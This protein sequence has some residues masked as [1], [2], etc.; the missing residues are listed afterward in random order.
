M[1]RLARHKPWVTSPDNGLEI[2]LRDRGRGAGNP[3]PVVAASAQRIV[4]DLRALRV[5]NVHELGGRALGGV[6][7]DGGGH[8]F[9]AGLHGLGVGVAAAGGLA[10][11]GWVDDGFRGGAWGCR[12]VAAGA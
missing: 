3:I 5:P 10:A 9:D 6:G 1:E 11:T 12:L 8:G 2:V 7:R 4:A